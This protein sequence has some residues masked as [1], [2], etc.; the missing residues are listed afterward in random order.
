[1][2]ESR[3]LQVTKKNPTFRENDVDSLEVKEEK[4]FFSA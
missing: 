1:V 3:P 2:K 4:N